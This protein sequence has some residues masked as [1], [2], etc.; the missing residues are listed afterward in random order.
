MRFETREDNQSV[1]LDILYRR[2]DS[3]IVK[4]KVM[5]GIEAMRSLVTPDSFY[6][7]DRLHK[8]LY[9]GPVDQAFRLLP[10]PGPLQELFESLSGA[11]EIDRGIDWHVSHD[12][13][14]Y[15]FATADQTTSLTVDPRLW[16][17]VMKE[18]RTPA[19]DLIERQ[20][21][22]DFD[23]FG[24]FVVPRRIEVY[25]PL[26]GERFQVYHRAVTVN[27]SPLSFQFETGTVDE[28]ILIAARD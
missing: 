7:Y 12:S 3:L 5:L 13:L 9:R 27:P 23:S 11:L 10:T 28:E 24:E 16:R 25:R 14:Y 4:A 15:Y 6:V 22:S 21:F 19:G 1:N 17:I 2:D 8:R 18:D 20:S 26:E